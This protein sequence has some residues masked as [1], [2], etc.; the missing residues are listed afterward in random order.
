MERPADDL[1]LVRAFQGGDDAAF[2]QLVRRYRNAVASFIVA[3][4]GRRA[5][6]EDLSQEV[7]LRV[8]QALPRF[9]PG[10]SFPSWL[11][12]ITINLCRDEIRKKRLRRFLSLDAMEETDH[13]MADSSARTD[14]AAS[15]NEQREVILAALRKIDGKY[16]TAL[17][18]REYEDLS[19]A[20]IARILGI[21]QGAVKS[22]IFR[23]RDQLRELLKGYF[24]ERT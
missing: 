5:D 4:L 1:E 21:T 16:R 3:T 8:H 20:Q 2:E 18:L 14:A 12:R 24:K 15:H 23:A 13:L 17:V 11:Y 22:R 19:Y 6:I 7:F 10:G 9:Q